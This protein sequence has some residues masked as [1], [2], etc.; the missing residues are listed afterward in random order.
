[1][2]FKN[3]IKAV[4]LPLPLLGLL[5]LPKYL[6]DWWN[7][8]RRSGERLR[9]TDAYPCLM[10]SVSA[11]PFDP[12]YF[13]Q[14]AWLARQL[15]KNMPDEHVDVGSSIMT[16]AAISG[17]VKVIFVDFRPL[18]VNL[19]NLKCLAGNIT[20]LPLQ[21][22]SLQSL[23]CLHVIEHI[24]LGRYGDPLDSN[25]SVAAAQELQRI[26]SEGGS[27]YLSTPVGRERTC[28][29]AHRVFDPQ[30]ILRMFNELALVEFSYVDDNGNLHE[31]AIFTNA[32]SEEY[33]CGL[34]HF[35]K[36]LRIQ[37]K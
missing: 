12:H 17:F 31:N 30:T 11:T 33:G 6:L 28:F 35:K 2:S 20:S 23:S 32:A 26:I 4:L 3:L 7:Y 29:N 34:F 9:L 14:G 19:L 16:I 10:D 18:K 24:G 27:L 1:M 37:I 13:Y 15:K 5:G 36:P 8:A 25:G 21:D 22:S